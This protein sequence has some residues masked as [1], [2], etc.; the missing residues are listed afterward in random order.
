[1]EVDEILPTVDGTT[2]NGTITTTTSTLP[3]EGSTVTLN[4]ND[5]SKLTESEK[6]ELAKKIRDENRKVEEKC[7]GFYGVMKKPPSEF[8]RYR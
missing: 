6:I 1:M 8:I 5:I 7:T 2:N 4:D 3:G